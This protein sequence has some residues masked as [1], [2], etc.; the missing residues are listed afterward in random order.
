MAEQDGEEEEDDPEDKPVTKS[1]MNLPIVNQREDGIEFLPTP[2]PSTRRRQKVDVESSENDLSQE[3][4]GSDP[5]PLTTR[6]TTEASLAS[7]DDDTTSNVD[8]TAVTTL[9]STGL[10]ESDDV[11]TI[12]AEEDDLSTITS[13]EVEDIS[14]SSIEKLSTTNAD[15]ISST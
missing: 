14:T 2:L 5:P 15:E 12:S 11:S 1:L 4:D 9:P 7:D 3:V 13:V 8:L 6:R 10:L